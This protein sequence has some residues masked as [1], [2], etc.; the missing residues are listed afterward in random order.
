MVGV[1]A[2]D[3]QKGFKEIYQN[4]IYAYVKSYRMKKSKELLVK[5]DLSIS[6]VANLVGYINNSKFSNAFKSEF[7]MTPSEYR[8]SSR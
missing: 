7:G 5:E 8:V 3:L 6:D 4:S 2:T 1:N